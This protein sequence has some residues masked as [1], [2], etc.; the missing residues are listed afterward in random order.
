MVPLASPSR[1]RVVPPA[2]NPAQQATLAAALR[3]PPR[4]AGIPIATWTWKAV[5][6]FLRQQ[7]AVGLSRSSCVRYLHRLDIVRKRPKKRLVK[8]DPDKRAAFVRT[9][10]DIVADAERRDATMLFVDEAH[11]RADAELSWLW[12]PRGESA[13]AP[14][15]SPRRAEKAAHYSAVCLET[16]TVEVME[17]VGTSSATT[18]VTFLQ[19]L[20]ATHTEPVIVIWGNAPA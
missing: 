3:Q 9:Y 1:R 12:T 13:L 11:F 15:T 5:A 8:A 14:S 20:R 7:F 16:G 17:L 4:V 18:S 6:Q 2:L 10:A 19:Q